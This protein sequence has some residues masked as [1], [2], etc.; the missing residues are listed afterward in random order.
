[1]RPKFA[2][3]MVRCLMFERVFLQVALTGALLPCKIKVVGLTV[4]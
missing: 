3:R 1:M 2:T 4:L